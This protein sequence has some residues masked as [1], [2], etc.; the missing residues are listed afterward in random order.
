MKNII[1]YPKE[2][3]SSENTV[4][5]LQI[6]QIIIRE[7]KKNKHKKEY[8]IVPNSPSEIGRDSL[9]I[10]LKCRN[11][12]HVLGRLA[13]AVRRKLLSLVFALLS[14]EKNTSQFILTH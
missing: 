10:P 3:L 9:H 4:F 8:N 1:L 12:F 5:L 14:N 13:M 6:S 11:Y 7:K 2:V